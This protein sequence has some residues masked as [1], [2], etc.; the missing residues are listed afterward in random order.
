VSW[1]E[2]T[3]PHLCKPCS[4]PGNA[5]FPTSGPRPRPHGHAWFKVPHGF[6][7]SAQRQKK[8]NSHAKS[9]H[10]E[11]NVCTSSAWGKQ[12]VHSGQTITRHTHSRTLLEQ[13]C[14][15]RLSRE[16]GGERTC[17]QRENIHLC[18]QTTASTRTCLPR[19][20]V[21]TP[22][23]PCPS[24][25]QLCL[26]RRQVPLPAR[27]SRHE[28]DTKMQL[29]G[30]SKYKTFG[31]SASNTITKAGTFTPA[32]PTASFIHHPHQAAVESR[33]RPFHH[34]RATR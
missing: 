24:C 23:Q 13:A 26:A 10:G 17:A 8:R 29:A 9:P 2:Q 28:I 20:P 25:W 32:T 15:T 7:I 31:A 27:T 30:K 4:T 21:V 33:E 12:P 18:W 1:E 6:D 34:S 3:Y 14:C 22:R 16:T 19:A 5:P 11:G